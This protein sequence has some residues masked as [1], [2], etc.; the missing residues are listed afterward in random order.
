MGDGAFVHRSELASGVTVI[1]EHVPGAR[2]ASLGVWVRVGSR[3][4]PAGAAG[5][6]HFLEH[7]LFKGTERLDARSIAVAVDAVGGEMNAY[8]AKEY[9]AFYMRVPAGAAEQAL[10]LLTEVVAAPAFRPAE[11]EAERQVILEELSMNEDTPDDLVHT[12]LFEALF[13]DHPL[14]WEVLGSAETIEAM[15]G[16]DI[17]GFFREHYHPANLVVAAAGAVD[18]DWVLERAAARFGAS[19]GG[20]RPRRS[21]PAAP[22]LRRVVER[23]PTEQAHLALGW[24]AFDH[25]DEDRYALQVLNQALGGG[26]SSRLFQEIRERRGLAY[27]V[28]SAP[29]SY[30]DSGALSVYVGTAPERVQQVLTLITEVVEAIRGEGLTAEEL[31][32]AVGFLEGSLLLGLE[33]TASRMSRLAGGEALRGRV[34]AVDEYLAGLRAVTLTD[35]A[36]VAERVLALE[37]VLA[38]VGPFP[39][40]AFG[41]V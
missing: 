6:S 41:P 35:A 32:T 4:E 12:R 13:P 39:A 16:A 7:L 38:A 18:H 37:P 25:H 24:R 26:L 10:D 30:S 15:S 2:S 27:S 28:Y 36:R 20:D 29:T 21:P 3:D 31:R 11:V 14:G 34:I 22:P 23:R 9:T 19:E 5:A 1:T 33:D 40:D 8:T 17:A